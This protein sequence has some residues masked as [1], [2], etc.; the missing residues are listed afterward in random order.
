MTHRGISDRKSLVP[1]KCIEGPAA[2]Q[3]SLPE[4]SS[5]PKFRTR[6]CTRNPNRNRN[7]NRNRNP[8]SPNLPNPTFRNA[9]PYGKAA[10]ERDELKARVVEAERAAEAICAS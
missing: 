5:D 2:A 3:T 6:T 7:R 4:P 9:K 10:A 1:G 8:K